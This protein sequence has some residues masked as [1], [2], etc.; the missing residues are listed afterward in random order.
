[1]RSFFIN[2]KFLSQK[3][4]GVQRYAIELFR[5]MDT[6][7]GQDIQ[8]V[9]LAPKNTI[10]EIE[11][12]NIQVRKTGHF[13]SHLWEHFELPILTGSTF[14]YSP[15]TAPPFLHNQVVTLHDPG[16]LAFPE[17]YSTRF[18]LFYGFV[19]RRLGKNAR[20]I[21]T[22]SEFSKSE[23]VTRCGIEKEK[24]SVVYPGSEHLMT[25]K[26][27]HSVF[28]RIGIN[29]LQPFFLGV[30]SRSPHKN[31]QAI[32]NAMDY[33]KDRNVPL[34]IAGGINQ[35]VFSSSEAQAAANTID[36]G[37]VTDGELRALYERA[38]CFIYPS[39]YEG[40]GLPPLEAMHSGCP[41]IV[42]DRA[43]LPEVCGEAALYCNPERPETISEAM[44][45]L[46]DNLAL[47]D[48]L[49]EKGRQ[50]VKLFTWKECAEKVLSHIRHFI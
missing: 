17:Y 38:Y 12:R 23:F 35:G 41:V 34:V 10:H 20:R 26:P 14:L 24:I 1:M 16:A 50:R 40:F 30:S 39:F 19:F 8:A 3:I 46:L 6:L 13:R 28:Q 4:T 29:P 47:R 36:A 32:I 42:S 49:I 37:Y 7:L 48:E 21:L 33:L 43:S 2:G 18:R 22:D 15:F 44:G 45:R 9:I 27:D 31:F 5:A 25:V 11:F